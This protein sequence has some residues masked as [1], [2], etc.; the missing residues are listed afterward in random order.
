MQDWQSNYVTQ[1]DK[2]MG[3]LRV[4]WIRY[5]QDFVSARK[6]SVYVLLPKKHPACLACSASSS[7]YSLHG[8]RTTEAKTR[9]KDPW[10]G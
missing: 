8:S 10:L 9:A 2:R 5:W 3:D 4:L 6:A 7:Q 1:R